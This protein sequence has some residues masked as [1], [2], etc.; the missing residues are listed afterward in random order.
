ML[1][2]RIGAAVVLEPGRMELTDDHKKDP[3]LL[4]SFFL[5]P[6]QAEV[7]LL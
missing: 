4:A 7:D 6:F 2:D 5:H 1:F 3:E